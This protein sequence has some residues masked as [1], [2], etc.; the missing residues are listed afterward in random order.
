[1]KY[2]L[3]GNIAL[4]SWRLV[5]YAYY[6]KGD[7]NAKGLKQEEY[8]LLRCCDGEQELELSPLLEELEQRGFCHPAMKGETLMEW[9]RERICD[10]RY[11][12]AINWMITGRCNYNCL[13][14]F[15]AADNNRL[16]S[17][18]TWDEAKRLISDAK[19]CGINAFT[20]TGGEPMLHPHFVDILKNIYDEGMYVEEL[21]TNGFFITQEILDKMKAI[22][23]TP[24]VKISF[25]GIGWHDWLRNK[26]GVQEDALRAIR[27]CVANGF[28]VKVQ[29]NV[30]RK[31]VSSML[32][33]AKLLNE[34]GVGEMRIIRTTESP[35]WVENAGDA[36][37]TLQ[38]YFDSMLLFL[39][40][41]V[42]LK[43]DME[44]D[45]W[46]FAHL[47]PRQGICNPSPVRCKEGEYRDSLPVCSGN[48]GMVAV[49]ANGNLYPC[50]QM[51][52]YY[53]KH[54]LTLGNVKKDGLQKHLKAG[55]YLNDVCTTVSE[56]AE[57]NKKCATC[58]WFK[59]CCGGC[60]ALGFALTGEQYGS[61]LSK[62]LFFEGGY[63]E[64]VKGIECRNKL[65]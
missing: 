14:C 12:P 19:K 48:R 5:P 13:H 30:H 26:K 2:I 42:K 20:I 3:S 22:G 21:N 56:L 8:E 44:I 64:K 9:Q 4:R 7:R 46:Q 57:Y 40:D 17:E 15:N 35:R 33:T 65:K 60:R 27:L 36:C 62:C 32:E 24:L 50:L 28:S 43:C 31:N 58:Q 38:E 63:L 10:N 51:S 54:N 55:A 47:S 53:D 41:Y 52:G 61:D 49:S 39:R 25:D 6:V 1:M 34:I 11:F 37:L 23:C 59:Q 16:Q 45:I 29:T 18:F